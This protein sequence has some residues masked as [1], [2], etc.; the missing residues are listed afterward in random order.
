[1]AFL[2]VADC[3][4]GPGGVSTPHTLHLGRTRVA[5]KA[6]LDSWLGAD[7]HYFKL[8]GEDGA[9]WIV[10]HDLTEDRWELTFYDSG[11]RPG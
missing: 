8:L 11:Q 5:L 2:I 10:R 4:P 6:L 9:T 1:M 3:R 7:H